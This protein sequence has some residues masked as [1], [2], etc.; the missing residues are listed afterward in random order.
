MR[1]ALCRVRKE[2]LHL[3]VGRE[4]GARHLHCKGKRVRTGHRGH[5]QVVERCR[6]I[7]FF[8]DHICGTQDGR[9]GG[10]SGTV[11]IAAASVRSEIR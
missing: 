7:C 1:A 2:R 4:S 11:A 8:Y 5:N 3:Q 10:I 9:I 6:T